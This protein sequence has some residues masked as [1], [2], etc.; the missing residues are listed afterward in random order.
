MK[1]GL[2]VALAS[3]AFFSAAACAPTTTD[4]DQVKIVTTDIPNFWRAYDDASPLTDPQARA[5]I[6]R[7]EYFDP[8]SPAIGAFTDGRLVGPEHLAA[9]VAKYKAYYASTRAGMSL[10]GAE[11]L[12]LRDDMR[13]FKSFYPAVAFPNVY[14]VVGA[15][16]SGGTSSAG[17]GLIIG[18]EKVSRPPLP[19]GVEP[20]AD[21]GQPVTVIPAMV[22]HELVHFNQDDGYS[23]NLLGLSLIEGSADFIGEL[24]DGRE[25]S[26]RTWTFG[27]KNEDAIWS[28]FSQQRGSSDHAVTDAC[29]IRIRRR[30]KHPHSSATG[31]DT[32]SFKAIT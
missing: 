22:S 29:S 24:A 21:A 7:R 32:G 16:N 5:D 3:I 13:R 4:P 28:L 9:V 23:Q 20:A 10:I 17:V 31:S 8:G 27:C 25:A 30:S 26:D 11:V 2:R 1:L 19:R 18:A 15:L 12:P 6:F 14:F